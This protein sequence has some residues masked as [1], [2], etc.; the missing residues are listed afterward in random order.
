MPRSGGESDKLGNRYEGLWTIGRLLE[1]AAGLTEAVTIEPFGDDSLGIEFWVRRLDGGRDFHSAKRQ[2]ARGEWSLAVLASKDAK[3]GRS[4]LSDLTEKLAKADGDRCCFVSST[5]AN[6]FRELTERACQRKLAAEF[7]ADLKGEASDTLRRTFEKNVLPLTRDWEAA[8]KQLQ[9]MQVTLI[10]EAT[11]TRQ[12]EQHISFLAYR[13]DSRPFEPCEVRLLLGNFILDHLGT[14]LRQDDVWEFLG[15]Y[16]YARRDWVSDPTIR[17]V[18]QRQNQAYLRTVEAD[19][20]NGARIVRTEASAIVDIVTRQSRT[21]TVLASATAGAGKSCVIAQAVVM[22]DLRDVPVLVV[23]LDRHGDA[24]STQ[25][26]GNQMQLPRSPAV[27]LAA[28]ANGRESVLV[29]D[30]LDAVSQVSGRYPQLW[31]LFDVLC[32]EAAA[33]P[34]MRMVVACR[35]FDL[36]NDSRLRKLKQPDIVEHIKVGL[37]S[38]AEVDTALAAGGCDAASFTPAQKEILR[39][40]LHLFLLLGGLDEE[41]SDV[42][43]ASIGDLF[44]RYWQRKQQAVTARLGRK[45]AWVAIIDK[46]CDAMSGELTVYAPGIVLD[47]HAETKSAMLTEHVLVQD[48]S[49]LRFFHESFFDYAYARRFSATGGNLMAL[50]LSSEQH[51]FRRSQVRQILAYMRDQMRGSYLA[52]LRELLSHAEVRFH[53][54][55]LVLAWLGPL[56][57]P[58]AD[59]WAIIEALLTDPD[60]Q[61]SAM[62]PIRNSLPWCEL[63]LQLGVVKKWLASPDELIVNRGVWFLL[64]DQ[65]QKQRSEVVAELLAP[66]RGQSQEW[67]NRLRAYFRFG[68]AHCTRAIQE[69]FLQ[70]VDDGVFDEGSAEGSGSIWHDLH[71]TGEKA[72]LFALEVVAHWLDRH[73]QAVGDSLDDD[74]LDLRDRDQSGVQLI[75]DAAHAEPGAFVDEILPRV[76]RIVELTQRA[77][78]VSLGRDRVWGLLNNTGPM[79]ISAAL[80]HELVGALENLAKSSPDTL[81]A[82]VSSLEQTESQTITFLLL[83]AWSANPSVFGNRCI[84]FLSADPRRL[85][86]GYSSWSGG[87]NG[88]AAVTREAIEACIPHATGE[89]RAQLELAIIGLS[90]SGEG[91]HAGWTECLLLESFGEQHLSEAGRERLAVLR[92]KFPQQDKA[93]PPRV[94]SAMAK[95]V[96][97]PV[98]PEATQRFTDDEWLTSMR[99][100]N[101]GWDSPRPAGELKGSAVELSRV[102]QPQARLDRRRFAALVLRMEDSIRQ[103]YFEAILD[104][105]S[106]FENLPAEVREKDNKDFEQLETD[107]VLSVV[108]RLHRLP[109]R[110]CGRSIC[111]VFEKLAKRSIPQADLEILARYAV[112]DPDPKADDW[113]ESTSDRRRDAAEDAHFY[114]YNS[115]R[116]HAARAIEALLFAD[117][118]RSAVML[119][120]I[121]A[122]VRDRS[123]AVRTCAVEALLPMLNHDRDAAVRLF[124]D[125][126]DG[127]DV[128]LGSHPFENFMRYATSTHYSQLRE[129]LKGALQSA[130][131]TTVKAASRQICLAGFTDDV[132]AADDEA[133]RNG[134]ESMRHAAAEVYAHNLGEGTVGDMC[135]QYLPQFFSDSAGDVRSTAGDC[136]L[137]LGD[138]DLN[139]FAD[140]IRTYIESPAFPSQHDDL[141]RQLDESTW[142]LPDITIRLAERFVAEFGAAAGDISTA[143]SGDAPTVSK[144]VIRLYTQSNDDAV[145]RRCLD[146]MDEMERLGFYGIDSQL[147]ELDR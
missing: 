54:K 97:S 33:Y 26:I 35:D 93:L 59:E 109:N 11:L 84:K 7:E 113:S 146:L 98:A 31:E 92:A 57:D 65:V 6:E 29:V 88:H 67:T 63:L 72:P 40:P 91:E 83:R 27:V 9:R 87:G 137:H 38:I 103:E 127:A 86:V 95:F 60:L 2:R 124:L 55:R 62:P 128:V 73:I 77:S 36:E 100:F 46:L 4:I 75:G 66:Y 147:A 3:T 125:A 34:N 78:G 116:G 13:P 143:A 37:L 121:Q 111:R 61:R 112:D 117:Y 1:L 30:Q 56:P 15:K 53:I 144:L 85:D 118:S 12:V 41:E 10:D 90:L 69:L 105:I 39:T 68:N 145:K 89:E 129:L 110:P 17:N 51:L 81:E 43:F 14:E 23:R 126:C 131:A 142:Q 79:R 45:S 120:L 74:A 18:V 32:Q 25:E 71:R 135:M 119:P 44:D 16:G 140:L 49:K 138:V 94:D 101:Y 130:A 28:L 52:Q 104:G 42:G 139:E 107:V 58:T 141:L 136:F 122:L 5:G 96:G 21:K 114:G 132:A 48:G 47:E 70:L 22:L 108:R 80:L 19:L 133:V 76:L 123:L 82:K 102:L 115:V 106:G 50:L 20:I 8:F 24:H 99:K 134:T 64:F